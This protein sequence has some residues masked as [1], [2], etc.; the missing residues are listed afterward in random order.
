MWVNQPLMSPLLSELMLVCGRGRGVIDRIDIDP[1]FAV[2]WRWPT[3]LPTTALSGLPTIMC[4]AIFRWRCRRPGGTL[5]QSRRAKAPFQ[6]IRDQRE[7]EPL[8]FL[9]MELRAEN[10]VTS[11]DRR[12]GTAVFG[13][14]HQV[15]S[16]S[17]D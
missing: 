5:R 6:K 7:T 16:G 2:I 11:H 10:I 13:F 1:N 12:Y 15:G 3:P 17:P 4:R 14:R 9:G 8:A